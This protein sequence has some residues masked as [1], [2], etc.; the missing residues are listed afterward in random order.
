MG[1]CTCSRRGFLRLSVGM[2]TGAALAAKFGL[3]LLAQE[4]TTAAKAKR[5]ILLWMMGAPSQMDT[6][7]PKPG[8]ETGGPFAAI[9][10]SA[11]GIRISENLPLVARQ[12]KHLSLIRTVNSRDPNHDTAQYLLH[13]AYRKAADIE[14]P[15]LGSVVAHELGLAVEDLPPAVVIGSA[16]PAGVGYL[17]ADVAPIVF[18]RLADPAED[19]LPVLN[20]PR[21]RLGRRWRMLQ[22]F[23]RRFAEEHEDARIAARR[24]ASEKAYQVL[25][26]ERVKAFDIRHEPEGMKIL[27]GKTDFG[28]ACLMAR[29]LVEAGVRFVE[30]MY[31]DWDT[32]ANNFERVK[33][34][35]TDIDRPMAALVQDLAQR[36]LLKETL[37]LWMGEFGRTPKINAANGRD[38]WTTWSVALGGGGIQPGRV[39]GQTDALGMSIADRPVPVNDLFATIYS[40]FGIQTDKKLITIPRP[41]KVIDGGSPVRELF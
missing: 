11:P 41:M 22:D 39:I 9:D 3:P 30:V 33:T 23:E 25:T 15:H 7:D 19:L 1:D 29:R 2:S 5:C 36:G 6:W 24:R 32:H 17:P 31:G 10:T 20:N 4:T 40:A 16:A 8:V 13:T 37:V 28:R 38:H 27:Y 26:S 34:L 12:M 21:E 14:H 18:D 35:S